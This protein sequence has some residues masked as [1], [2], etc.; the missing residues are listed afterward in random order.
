MAISLIILYIVNLLIAKFIKSFEGVIMKRF[1]WIFLVPLLFINI[2]KAD[3]AT[4][5]RFVADVVGRR[6]RALVW[7]LGANDGRF[8]RIAALFARVGRRAGRSCRASGQAPLRNDGT[9]CGSPSREQSA[10]GHAV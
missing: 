3:L 7:D 4:K 2:V 6:P 9:R 5:E 8:S 10:G 1:N